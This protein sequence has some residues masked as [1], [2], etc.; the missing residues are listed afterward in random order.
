MN[1][2]PLKFKSNNN[3]SVYFSSIRCVFYLSKVIHHFYEKFISIVTLDFRGYIRIIIMTYVFR[4]LF[5]TWPYHIQLK[6]V[7]LA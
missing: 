1:H 2:L 5:R 4:N 6:T 3:I 7:S